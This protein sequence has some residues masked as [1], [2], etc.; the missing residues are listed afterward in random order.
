MITWSR[1]ASITD[2]KPAQ[3]SAASFAEFVAVLDA[4]RAP[5]KASA[6][7][8]CG[9]LNGDGRRCAEGAQA[10]RWLALDFDKIEPDILPDL[11]MWMARF[12][13]AGWPTHSSTA[14]K[15]R[16]RA[17]L[18]L[19]RDATRDECIEVGEVLARDLADEFGDAIEL[20]ASTFRPEQAIYVPPVA[21]TLA[22]FDGEPL[23]VDVYVATAQQRRK[24]APE[25]PQSS[26][27]GTDDLLDRLE[28]GEGLHDALA[29]FIA[30]WVAR[31]M[32]AAAVRAAALG[33]LERARK[34]RGA[35]VDEIAGAEL[36]RLITGAFKK[37][38]PAAGGLPLLLDV[39]ELAKSEPQAPQ[40]VVRDWLPCGEVTLLAGHGGSGKSAIALYAAICI[41]AGKQFYGM[42][43][44]RRRVFLLSLEDSAAVLHWRALRICDWLGVELAS[45]AGWLTLA[46]G[47]AAYG[48]LYT[49]TTRNEAALTHVYEW[50]AQQMASREVLVLD[51][52]SDAYGADEIRRRHVRAFV[53]AVRRLVPATGAALMLGHID[54]ASAKSGETSQGYSGSTAWN[55][56]VRSRWYLRPD[57][58]ADLLLELQKSNYSAAGAQ[59]RVRW[60]DEAHVFAGAVVMPAGRLERELAEVD[61]RQAILATIRAAQAAGDAIPTASAGTRTTYSVCEA[62][63]DFPS[64]LRSRAGRARF[65]R[66]LEALRA[67]GAVRAI[68]ERKGNRH[69]REVFHAAE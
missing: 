43:T 14:D 28:R 31:G 64:S 8:V 35:R 3:R 29:R 42:A 10:R 24:D 18:E 5:S 50:V 27:D 40:F 48:E 25:K 49:E 19:S 51:G 38:A 54:K 67:C 68:E 2:N 22:R 46:D 59:V 11:R 47:S 65:N 55:N 63:D 4:D 26:P 69:A 37:Y 34:V 60:L 23:D 7:Y 16:E 53:R 1:G 12:S 41:A 30:Q 58:D 45:L 33:L 15:P 44:E 36:E 32:D 17:V 39:A 61:E 9:G 21:V 66:H 52:I 56:S 6:G 20:D 13:G 62:R 57:E